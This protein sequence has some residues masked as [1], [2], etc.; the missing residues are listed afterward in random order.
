M[1]STRRCGP[2]SA[3]HRTDVGS[4]L[5]LLR[6]DV[7]Q[8]PHPLRPTLCGRCRRLPGARRARAAPSDLAVQLRDGSSWRGSRALHLQEHVSSVRRLRVPPSCKRR[9]RDAKALDRPARRPGG[10]DSGSELRLIDCRSE[11]REL[12]GS[13]FPSH[14]RVTQKERASA[15]PR[16]PPRQTL[17]SAASVRSRASASPSAWTGWMQT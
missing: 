10:D 13:P 1:A 4:P 2:P 15:S 5:P 7:Q 12:S 14:P 11:G 16:R 9:G 3:A 6:A 17:A 8:P